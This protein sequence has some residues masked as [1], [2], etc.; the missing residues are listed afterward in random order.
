[1]LKIISKIV[2]CILFGIATA[3]PAI[4]DKPLSTN[5]IAQST[6]YGTKTVTGVRDLSWRSMK[7][8]TKPKDRTCPQVYVDHP[9]IDAMRNA[10]PEKVAVRKASYYGSGSLQGNPLNDGDPDTDA[11]FHECDATVVASNEYESGTVL[12]LTNRDNG[13]AITV[14]VQDT[15]GPQVDHRL[16]LARGAAQLL[17]P[18]YWE[19]GVL[20][21]RVEVLG[22]PEIMNRHNK[23]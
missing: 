2:A 21:L 17:D 9:S 11:L 23:A 15:G 13:R 1:M 5:V 4:A 20:R 14:V 10:T 6:L 18:K 12:R 16:D 3:N 22:Q 7:T 19:K 8:G